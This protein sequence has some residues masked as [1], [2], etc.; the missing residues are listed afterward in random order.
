MKRQTMKKNMKLGLGALALG[1][2]VVAQA[3]APVISSFS[4]NGV[5]VCTNLWPGTMAAVEWAP[6]VNSPW[7]NNWAGL[8]SVTVDSNRMIQVSVPMFYRVRGTDAPS[9]MV[10]IPA[11]SFAMG[12]CM[13]PSEGYSTELP[14]HT[15]RVSAFY[16]DTNE[17]DQG[18]VG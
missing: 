1:V 2:C 17:V 14:L 7:T 8:D 9:G 11:G 18:A 4:E 10:L 5:L 6:S 16:M 13:N 3:A 15:V 12:N